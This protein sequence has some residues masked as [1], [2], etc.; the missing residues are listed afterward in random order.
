MQYVGHEATADGGQ[1]SSSD[2]VEITIPPQDAPVSF[3]PTDDA[4]LEDGNR[5][6]NEFLKVQ[7]VGRRR[8][9]YLKYNA[10]GLEVRNLPRI[11]FAH[12]PPA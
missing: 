7:S 1:K 4:Y 11:F 8:T 12:L 3:S 6:N 9:S 10:R 2:N 5:H